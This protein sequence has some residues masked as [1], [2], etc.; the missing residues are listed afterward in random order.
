MEKNKIDFT[1]FT[2]YLLLA[3]VGL[4]S[5]YSAKFHPAHP[6]IFALQTEYGRQL[7]WIVLS[8]SVG[9]AILL[10]DARWMY[11]LIYHGYIFSMLLLVLVLLSEPINGS[12]SWFRLIGGFSFQPSELAKIFTSLIL[13]RYL[14]TANIKIKDLTTKISASF[15]IGLPAL[16][17][18][19][20]P[21]P[22]TV[23]VFVFF[24]FVLY[25]EG[26]S[27][28]FLFI[29]LYC[30]TMSVLV[31]FFRE[32][33]LSFTPFNWAISAKF[34]LV[35]LILLLGFLIRLI[36]FRALPPSEKRKTKFLTLSW[37]GYLF[38]AVGFIFIVEW[39]FQNVLKSHHR[40]RIHLLLGLL[41]DKSGVGYNIYRA[42]T[43]IGSG[44]FWGRGYQK[45][46]LAN[47]E[48]KHVPEQGTD[49]IFCS[50]GEEWGFAGSSLIILIYTLFLLRIIVIAERQKTAF[51]RIFAYCVGSIFFAHF[52]I[53]I[54]MVIGLL[55]VIGIPLP[56]ISY[57]GS[58]FLGFSV[59]VFLLLRFNGEKKL[60]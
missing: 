4:A 11:R 50:I 51:P 23:L 56:F 2:L 3:L 22:G 44:Q 7:L 49:F 34:L 8:L 45:S 19:L 54:G 38:G 9:F 25:R 16:L 42:L 57:G 40:D 21:D 60:Q 39:I 27:S 17:I 46:I 13:A 29:G 48:F 37:M 26:L 59:L 53:N 12:R 33:T 20:Q 15:F 5:V 52:L 1:L 35:F 18:L 24:I 28:D 10:L 31:L 32:N 30:V 47:D 36:N 41:E 58:S 6:E 55:P 43:A 14:S